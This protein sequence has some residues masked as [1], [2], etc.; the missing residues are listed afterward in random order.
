MHSESAK[1]VMTQHVLTALKIKYIIYIYAM[2]VNI[3]AL[4]LR[5]IFPENRRF[6]SPQLYKIFILYNRAF[7]LLKIKLN[8]YLIILA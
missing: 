7:I 3:N 1:D 8:I 2:L 5:R 4:T 6:F